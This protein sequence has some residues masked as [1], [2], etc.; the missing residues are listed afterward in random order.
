MGFLNVAEIAAGGGVGAALLT[1]R[2]GYSITGDSLPNGGYASSSFADRIAY[3]SGG[4]YRTNISSDK[5]SVGGT[6]TDQVATQ[7]SPAIA[8]GRATCLYAA[9]T[10]DI[11][12][13][14]A[15]ATIQTN[16]KAAWAQLRAAGV[17]PL[18]VGMFP[19]NSSASLAAARANHEIW[20]S[21]Y[22][23]KN[24]VQHVSPWLVLA[25][26]DGT[27][28]TGYN[29]DTIHPNALAADA[30]AD[31][32]IAQMDQPWR[33][34]PVLEFIDRAAASNVILPN[35]VSFGGVGAALPAGYFTSGSSGTPSY[36]VL[37]ADANDF[38][39]WLRTT[40]AGAAGSDTGWQGTAQTLANL[41]MSIGDKILFACRLRWSA[42]VK[43]TITLTGATFAGAYNSPVY[44]EQDGGSGESYYIA[45][46]T[47]ISAGTV[48]GLKVAAQSSGPGYFEVNRPLIYN[49]TANGL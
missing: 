41:G 32:C 45:F 9:G 12:Q 17:E 21:Y 27:Y 23:G 38:G 6:R 2:G 35:A 24:G 40:F 37:A 5:F 30:V 47:T 26:A 10:N 49:L 33:Q 18:D 48:L 7:L 42:G 13:S 11:E 34:T 36:S 46:E 29:Y 19:R 28:K 25:N 8:T 39:G 16:L 14:I 1:G 15:A 31:L 20:R 3:R 22:C 44:Q 43:P 4:R